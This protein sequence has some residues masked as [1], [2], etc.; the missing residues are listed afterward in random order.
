MKQQQKK[1]KLNNTAQ[2]E[3]I[4][5][6]MTKWHPDALLISHQFWREPTKQVEIKQRSRRP[7]NTKKSFIHN[8]LSTQK[9]FQ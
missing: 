1:N 4:A 5:F 2:V 3:Q 9:A 7:T 8:S 6:E